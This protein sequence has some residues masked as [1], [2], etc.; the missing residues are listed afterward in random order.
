MAHSNMGRPCGVSSFMIET[1]ESRVL[2]ASLPGQYV[3]QQL[4][5]HLSRPTNMRF[6]PD[7]RLFVAEQNGRLLVIKNGQLLPQP[8]ITLNV[9]RSGGGGLLR[10]QFA[11]AFQSNP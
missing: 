6:S 2:L 5:N 7:G 1:L 8:F 3:E 4:A 11:P 9:D 10:V